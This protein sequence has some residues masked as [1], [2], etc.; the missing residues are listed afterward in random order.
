[1]HDRLGEKQETASTRAVCRVSGV[2][3]KR[4]PKKDEAYEGG[5]GHAAPNN[6]PFPVKGPAYLVQD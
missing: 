5:C 6:P 1:M 4:F 3:L 2:R